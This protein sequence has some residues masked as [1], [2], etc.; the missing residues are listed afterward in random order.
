MSKSISLGLE[1]KIRW[2]LTGLH[3]KANSDFSVPSTLH[4]K[5]RLWWHSS[6]IFKDANITDYRGEGE[7]NA[8]FSFYSMLVKVPSQFSR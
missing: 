4:A 8:F 1:K 2:R 3:S 5:D 7:C 6:N